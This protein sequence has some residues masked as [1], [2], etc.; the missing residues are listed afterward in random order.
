MGGAGPWGIANGA[1]DARATPN[2]AIL[3]FSARSL[4]EMD[5]F[6]ARLFDKR[7]AGGLVRSRSPLFGGRKSH[8]LNPLSG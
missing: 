3:M 1:K 8:P 4:D 7:V 2:F 5:P 6:G